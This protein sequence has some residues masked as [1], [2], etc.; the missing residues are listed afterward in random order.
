LVVTFLASEPAADSRATV[1]ALK[2]DPEEMHLLG[3]ELYIYFPDGM[4]RSKL[5]P[6]LA[7]ALKNSG[8]A[9]NWNTVLK[10]LDIAQGLE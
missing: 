2:P 4:G 10:L 3:R 8:T 7:K 9:R 1:L 5:V 6:L